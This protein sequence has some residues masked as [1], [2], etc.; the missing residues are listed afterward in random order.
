MP[1]DSSD[2]KFLLDAALEYNKSLRKNIATTLFQKKFGKNPPFKKVSSKKQPARN[3]KKEKKSFF[4]AKVA[5]KL[6]LGFS[7][8]E[9]IKKIPIRIEKL[10]KQNSAWQEEIKRWKSTAASNQEKIKALE[11]KIQKNLELITDLKKSLEKLLKDKEKGKITRS[12]LKGIGGEEVQLYTQDASSINGIYLDANKFRQKLKEQGGKFVTITREFSNGQK[13]T[14][15]GIS[16]PKKQYH[17]EGHVS[18]LLKKLNGIA[19][20]DAS[21]LK[22]GSG[23]IEVEC[24]E[25][26]LLTRD[27]HLKDLANATQHEGDLLAFNPSSNSIYLSMD[28]KETRTIKEDKEIIISKDFPASTAIITSGVK[29]VYEMHKQEALA[30]LFKGMN[31]FL[32]N[33][34]GYGESQGI[35]SEKGFIEDYEEALKYVMAR[36]Q[37]AEEQI[38]LKAICLSGG[39]AAEIGARH[40]K[41]NLFLDQT[42]SDFKALVKEQVQEIAYESLKRGGKPSLSLKTLSSLLGRLATFATPRWKTFEALKKNAGK[43]LIMYADKDELISFHHILSFVAA[44]ASSGKLETLSLFEVPGQHGSNWLNIRDSAFAHSAAGKQVKKEKEDLGQLKENLEKIYQTIRE[45]AD[46]EYRRLIDRAEKSMDA[47]EAENL[48]KQAQETLENAEDFILNLQEAQKSTE[49]KF[50][51]QIISEEKA[52]D[53]QMKR[54][55]YTARDQLSIFLKRS[56]LSQ[57]IIPLHA[58]SETPERTIHLLTN[59]II[60]SMEEISGT[61]QFFENILQQK[62]AKITVDDSFHHFKCYTSEKKFITIDIPNEKIALMKKHFEEFAVLK[63]RHAELFYQFPQG[64]MQDSILQMEHKISL[65]LDKVAKEYER[66]NGKLHHKLQEERK[67]FLDELYVL[68]QEV[69]D[70][71]QKA[72]S[73]YLPNLSK[74]LLAETADHLQKKESELS[75]LDSDSGKMTEDQ[76]KQISSSRTLSEEEKE[77]FL[78]EIKEFSGL[79]DQNVQKLVRQLF[80]PLEKFQLSVEMIQIFSKAEFLTENLMKKITAVTE[81]G[82]GNFSN[83]QGD[84]LEEEIKKAKKD[85]SDLSMSFAEKK[86]A[87]EEL[88]EEFA[89]QVGQLFKE[90]FL[91]LKYR[92]M[93]GEE[94]LYQTS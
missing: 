90:T 31:V 60:N 51:Q 46:M 34:R 63:G 28:T 35:P 22:P 38:L 67:G 58:E 55:S 54:H 12:L 83:E 39:I 30:F 85:L 19:N 36:S 20:F 26:I 42:Y 88:D 8:N 57:D 65:L 71:L 2:N 62:I 45:E 79:W 23:W 69:A 56:H 18:S 41:L 93:E 6:F 59:Q 27:E 21:N 25:E 17:L 10:E 92:L 87:L 29:G 47:E 52:S 48:K 70:F 1:N 15:H 74:R 7:I 14:I 94:Q 40:P 86:Q 76:K 81:N 43:K 4:K 84:L 11:D 68:D 82:S 32:F 44:L 89:N 9:K 73:E 53:S 13:Q 72:E 3:S 80:R 16:F 49:E 5:E 33:F 78:Q 75:D 77:I 37:C 91:D 64:N 61:L 24:G 50:Q 66:I